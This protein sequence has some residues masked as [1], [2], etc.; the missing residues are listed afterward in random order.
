MTVINSTIGTIKPGRYEDFVSQ[1]LEVS[2][3][4]ERLGATNV[5]L[6]TAGVAGE[7]QG[8][9]VFNTEH[10]DLEQY[11]AFVDHLLADAE[12]LALMS[13]LQAPDNAV[14]LEQQ[15]VA[16]EIPLGRDTKTT[17]PGP[18]VETHVTRVNP[19]G[20]DRSLAEAKQACDFIEAHGARNARLCQ[21][22]YAGSFSGTYMVTWEFENM[23]AWGKA[24]PAPT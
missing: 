5:R 19:G 4:M 11:G 1:G 17:T 3:L 14:T 16:V 18:I 8:R 20:L 7:Q 15:S 2:K 22:L 12:M 21:L 6:L 24:M 9:W 23:R 10:T 13:R